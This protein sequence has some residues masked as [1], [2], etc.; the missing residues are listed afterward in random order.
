MYM[1]LRNIVLIFSVI[2]ML[3]AGCR[4]AK[5]VTYFKDLEQSKLDEITTTATP[6][7]D[8]VIKPKDILQITIQTIDP[9][10]RSVIETQSDPK[11]SG[12]SGY[13]VSNEGYIELLLLGKIKVGGL[14][15]K[16][17]EKLIHS[18]V[19]T[20]YKDPVVSVRL[21]NFTI[22]VLGEVN[23]P[24]QQ[25]VVN[26][27]VSILDAIGM[28]GDLTIFGKRE[29]V[30]LITEENG[31]KKFVRFNLSSSTIF[32][33]KYFYLRQNDILYIEPSNAKVASNDMAT[34]R[35]LTILTSVLSFTALIVTNIINLNR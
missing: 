33:S 29:N 35:N 4:S 27:K 26:E 3:T 34:V 10:N 32:Q 11:T 16:E 12:T 15:T 25:L 24:G 2:A 19:T 8:P 14:T 18:R 31:V 13:L 5:D 23:R 7:Q 20:L 9:T 22:T 1:Q 21:A 28:A 30:L 17:I 6:Y